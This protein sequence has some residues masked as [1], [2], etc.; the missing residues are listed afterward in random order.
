MQD[1]FLNLY[2]K[3][4]Q[5]PSGQNLGLTGLWLAHGDEPLLQQ[6]LVDA[7][8][9]SWNMQNLAI[10]RIELVSAKTWLDVLTELNSLSL[11]DDATAVIISGNHKPDKEVQQQLEAFAIEANAGSNQN[12]V[13]WLSSKIDKRA[14]TSKWFTPFAKFGQVVDC[15]LY[16]ENQRQQLLAIH[17]QRFGLTLQPEAWQFLMV[18]TEHHLLSAYQALWRLSYLFAPQ[19][20]QLNQQDAT[21]TPSDQAANTISIDVEALQAALVSDAQYSVFDLSDAML[22]GNAIQVV[23]IIEQLRATEEPTPLVL[24]AI[25]KDMRLIMQLI[26]GQNPQSLGI[27]SSKQALYQAACHRQTPQSIADW[28]DI[29]YQCDK[30]VKGVLRQPAWELILQAALRVTGV[31]LFT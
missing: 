29:L 1:S 23:R 5:H 8:R 20:A 19:I 31:Q 15:N 11:F 3:L 25:G 26:D 17:A 12:C 14:Q 30:A 18:Q 9:R 27:W 13:L 28:P 7:M 4:E 24:W 22:A 6:W 10:K 16:N 21:S 2:P